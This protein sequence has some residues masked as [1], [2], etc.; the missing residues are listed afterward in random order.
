MAVLIVFSFHYAGGTHASN[1]ALQVFGAF[2]KGGWSGVLLF[3]VLSGFLITGI[4]WRSFEA[5]GWWCRFVARR[6]LRIFPL[7]YLALLLCVLAAIPGGT[8]PAAISRI[9]APA[10][11][12][13]NMPYF[14]GI[15]NTLPS[16]VALF[17][18]WSI[19]VEEQFY[20]V[21]PWLL[22][23]AGTRERAKLLCVSTVVLS[24]VCRVLLLYLPDGSNWMHALPCEAGPLAAG[25]WLALVYLGPEWRQIR[26][27]A[28]AAAI[29]GLAGFVLVGL[30]DHDFGEAGL[31][32][33]AGVPAVTLFFLSAIGLALE[34]G[35]VAAFFSMRWLRGLGNI[36]YGVYV[37]HMLFLSAYSSIVDRLV[38]HAGAMVRNLALL[39]VAALCS[40]TLAL[41][42]YHL[43]EKRFLSLKRYF[44]PRPPAVAVEPADLPK[45]T[46]Y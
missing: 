32:S 2:N 24:Q 17:H 30:V 39:L 13:E 36:S 11:F 12:L 44:E 19:A 40:V 43:F 25:A 21:W 46:Q 6:S 45:A 5:A 28:P 37:F 4:L 18:L 41:L 27:F 16:P 42:S 8:F 29:L 31:M 7:Y 3:F 10:L 26:R 15:T 35:P 23:W 14:A 1:R 20:L 38:P 34:A 22:L 33:T 9:G